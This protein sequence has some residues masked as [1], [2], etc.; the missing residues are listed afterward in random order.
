MD[1]DENSRS[2]PRWHRFSELVAQEI[3]RQRVTDVSEE[4][5]GDAEK[6]L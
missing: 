3:W 1:G 6:L 2:E 4:R 5:M